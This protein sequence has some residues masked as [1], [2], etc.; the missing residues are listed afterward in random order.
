MAVAHAQVMK[1]LGLPVTAIGRGEASAESFRATTGL[2]VVTGGL[3]HA[4][5]AL[6]LPA[7]GAVIATPVD[8]LAANCLALIRAGVRRILVEKPAGLD[9]EQARE[10]AQAAASAGAEVFVAYNRRFYASVRKAAELIAADGGALSLRLEFSEFSHRISALPSS[11]AVK[12]AWLYAN[13]T[14]VL[15]LGFFLAGFPQAMSGDVAGHLDWHP[16]GARFVGHGR[17]VSGALFSWHA[18]WDGAPRWMVE[19]ATAR[20]TLMFQPLEKL[21]YRDKTGFAETAVDL[22]TADTDFKPGL[23]RQMEAFAAG[24]GAASGLCAIADHAAHMNGPYRAIRSGGVW[25][26]AALT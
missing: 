8:V 23:L 5:E 10:L 24:S 21:R 9:P 26:A 6:P 2:D 7:S 12:Q 20:R 22:D 14:H 18:D 19:I 25:V 13:S 17:T 16:A 15:D 11:A 3:D 4:L 1:H